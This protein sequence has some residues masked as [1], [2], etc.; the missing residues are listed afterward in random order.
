MTFKRIQ[1]RLQ[2]HY[3]EKLSYGT[4]VE[5]CVP[6][7]KRHTASKRYKGVANVRY[8]QARK[9]FSLKY[10]PDAKWSRSFYK[11]LDQVQKDGTHILLL[12]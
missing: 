12:N 9:G 1:E 3:G 6:R 10:N 11:C 8:Q 7:N 2:E 5:L 4:I